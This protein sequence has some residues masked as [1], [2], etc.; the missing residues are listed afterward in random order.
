M[1]SIEREGKELRMRFN[2][3]VCPLTHYHY[4]VF[5]LVIEKFEMRMKVSFATNV[6]GAIESFS[7]P[8]EPTVKD[9]VF[10]RRPRREL[11]TLSYLEQFVGEYELVGMNM[12]V[13]V[14]LKGDSALSLTVPGQP[15]YDLEPYQESE[16]RVKN[17]SDYRIVFQRDDGGKVREA[18]LIQPG[19]AFTLKKRD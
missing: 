6:R 18:L 2:S 19:G 11:T 10:T 16:F 5:E 17:L 13:W 7:A 3:L 15:Q 8:L 1:L 14:A 12:Q 4:D 9:I